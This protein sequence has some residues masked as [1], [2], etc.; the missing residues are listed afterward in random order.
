M[1]GYQLIMRVQQKMQD[2]VFAQRFYKTVGELQGIP[3]LQQE[4]LRIAQIQDERKREKALDRL[5]NKVKKAVK[6]LLSMVEN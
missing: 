6:D 2:P 4:V 5:P 1:N 3:G